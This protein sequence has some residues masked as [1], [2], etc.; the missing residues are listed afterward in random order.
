LSLPFDL[1]EHGSARRTF[2]LTVRPIYVFL[3]DRATALAERRYGIRTAGVVELDDLGIAGPDR[4]RYKPTPWRALRRGLP[5]ASVNHEDV[6]LDLGS[7]M[8]RVVVQ[9]G[10]HYP[11]RRVI[12]VELSSSLHAVAVENVARNQNRFRGGDV[13]LVNGDVTDFEIPDDITVVFL[14]NPFTGETFSDV[15]TRLV[16][17][18]RRSPRPLRIVYFNPV[19]H[20]RLL[21]TG[22][23]T[24]VRRIRGRRPEAEWA[25]SNSINVYRI[26]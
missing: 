7:G 12:G 23:I 2:D 4:S 5:I 11:F 17:S 3:R 9:A 25:R 22:A 6:F 26:E 13:V 14:N 19:E 8:G 16:A 24:L 18:V 15:A 10:L 21:S 1:G 20:E